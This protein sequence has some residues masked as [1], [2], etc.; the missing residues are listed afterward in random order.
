[1]LNIN[2]LLSNLQSF[3]FYHLSPYLPIILAKENPGSC[4]A[5]CCHISF[6][7]EMFLSFVS[8]FQKVQAKYFIDWPLMWICLCLLVMRLVWHF[9]QER[10]RINALFTV[11]HI[12]RCAVLICPIAVSIDFDNL[13]CYLPV[14]STAKL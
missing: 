11:R 12:K 7:M 5:L 6:N 9:W 13:K 4:A 14:F 1:M 10:C 3:I 8:V 2:T